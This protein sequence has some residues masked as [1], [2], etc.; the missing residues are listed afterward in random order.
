MTQEPDTATNENTLPAAF[1]LVVPQVFFC[2]IISMPH[3][4]HPD[5]GLQLFTIS[6]SAYAGAVCVLLV[7]KPV[8]SFTSLN[9]SFVKY[10]YVPVYVFTIWF[11]LR[12]WK[13]QYPILMS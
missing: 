6:V 5:A 10:G 8:K 13:Y 7:R 9:W 3:T 2:W 1:G 4:Y 11:A 12:I